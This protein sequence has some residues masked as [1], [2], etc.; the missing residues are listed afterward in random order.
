MRTILFALL[1]AL[2]QLRAAA[3]ETGC[4]YDLSGPVQVRK[5]GSADWTPA[6]KGLPL[7][8]GDGLRTGA[9]AWCEALFRDG[10]FV[11]LDADSETAAETL[12]ASAGER[13]F[14]FSFLKG[15]ALWM[16]A[17]VK[18]KT[19]S[20]FHVR[21]PAAVCAVRGTAFSIA[22]STAG[23][24]SVGLFE[25]KVAV[26]GE[27]AEK[28]LLP[29]NEAS[30]SPGGVLVQARL[31]RLMK[32]E[33]R[34]YARVKGRVESLRKRLAERDTFIDDYIGRQRKSLSDLEKRREEKLG[35]R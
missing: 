28:E 32:A 26:S 3:A 20:K 9:G 10:T 31:S 19:A 2:P 35:K 8:E 1:L 16:A 4:V 29:G 34:R 21:T 7:S 12:K 5:A 23:E 13:L 33:E 25:G 22:V 17:K 11:K 18:E 15:K 30:A 27:G 6:R 14:S 24:T